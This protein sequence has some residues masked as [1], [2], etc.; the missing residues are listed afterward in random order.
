VY[1]VELVTPALTS[2][3]RI[4]S[5]RPSRFDTCGTPSSSRCVTVATPYDVVR[6]LPSA[7]FSTVTRSSGSYVYEV[8]PAGETPS[9]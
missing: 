4:T 2:S 3:R 5:L 1:E 9:L 6:V 7:A 8:T